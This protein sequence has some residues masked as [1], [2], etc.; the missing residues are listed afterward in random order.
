MQQAQSPSG[1]NI[2][3]GGWRSRE[4]RS[5]DEAA[6]T[7]ETRR[8]VLSTIDYTVW[9]EGIQWN[10]GSRISLVGRPATSDDSGRLFEIIVCCGS[11]LRTAFRL[12]V[13]TAI[14]RYVLSRQLPEQPGA[15]FFQLTAWP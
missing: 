12:P 6:L 15:L 1:V 2:P 3:T 4:R 10:E 11:V 5:L 7:T 14:R 9:S 13:Y 8:A